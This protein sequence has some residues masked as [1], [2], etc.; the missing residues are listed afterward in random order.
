MT[1]AGEGLPELRQDFLGAL[2]ERTAECSWTLAASGVRRDVQDV[3]G[4]YRSALGLSS[5]VSKFIVAVRVSGL[6]PVEVVG[7]PGGMASPLL[8]ELKKLASARLVAGAGLDQPV[9][10][11]LLQNSQEMMGIPWA[12]VRSWS[13][14]P[15]SFRRTSCL[16]RMG[17]LRS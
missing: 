11:P 3:G 8:G 15:S 5:G 1:K 13:T 2:P 12:A 17:Y 7:L 16:R 10:S 14:T 9:K 6:E 4:E